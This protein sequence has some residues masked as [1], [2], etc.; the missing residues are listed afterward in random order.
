MFVPTAISPDRDG[1][2]DELTAYFGCD[3]EYRILRLAVFDRWGGQV[4]TSEEGEIPA[5]D[6]SARGKPMSPGT[7][8]WYLEYETLRNG[9][10]ERHLEKGEVNVIR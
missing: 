1:I 2:N 9:K 6:G 3:Y 10:A 8:V 5:W 7:Y 4:Y